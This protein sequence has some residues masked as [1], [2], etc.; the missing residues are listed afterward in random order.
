MES[1]ERGGG[2]G[3][4]VIKTLGKVSQE[5]CVLHDDLSGVLFGNAFTPDAP[6]LQ[7]WTCASCTPHPSKKK[8]CE[9]KS[10]AWLS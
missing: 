9:I 6:T 7:G 8:G 1:P 2:G 3:R 5:R 10:F 4:D